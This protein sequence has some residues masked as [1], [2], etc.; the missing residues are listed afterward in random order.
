MPNGPE[1]A[2]WRTPN[3][4]GHVPVQGTNTGESAREGAGRVDAEAS[5]GLFCLGFF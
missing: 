4:G 2:H 1:E 5:K 3:V